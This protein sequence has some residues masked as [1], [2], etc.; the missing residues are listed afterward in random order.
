MA[1]V[2]TSLSGVVPEE[3]CKVDDDSG[4]GNRVGHERCGGRGCLEDFTRKC[5]REFWKERG[6]RDRVLLCYYE[7]E[8]PNVASCSRIT[9]G[10]S[11]SVRGW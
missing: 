8:H 7:T 5:F 6:L 11:R 4:T 3:R 10:H 9:T 2:V 1:T